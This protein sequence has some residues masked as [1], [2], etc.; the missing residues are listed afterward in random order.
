MYHLQQ[1][2]S[3]YLMLLSCLSFQSPSEEKRIHKWLTFLY[4]GVPDWCDSLIDRKGKVYSYRKTWLIH[5]MESSTAVKELDSYVSIGTDFQ[6]VL[7]EKLGY[8][9]INSVWFTLSTVLSLPSWRKLGYLILNMVNF[10]HW[11]SSKENF[12]SLNKWSQ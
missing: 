1:K 5:T 11:R 7:S 10:D 2:S 12:N 8:R 3:S 9:M 4:S 6:T